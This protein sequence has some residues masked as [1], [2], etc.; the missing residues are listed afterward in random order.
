MSPVLFVQGN[1]SLNKCCSHGGNG[2]SEA[3]A[4][5]FQNWCARPRAVA[6]V[7]LKQQN[8]FNTFF[9]DS[10]TFLLLTQGN[11]L[12]QLPTSMI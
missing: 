10:L 7:S 8:I 9:S 12:Q 4:W 2:V 11:V 5:G 1:F 3:S 6:H